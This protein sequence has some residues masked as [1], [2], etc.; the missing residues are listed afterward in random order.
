MA[1]LSDDL[2]ALRRRIDDHAEEGGHTEPHWLFNLPLSEQVF[3]RYDELVRP[4]FAGIEQVASE[5]ERPELRQG[6]ELIELTG[7]QV[8]TLGSM[9]R[10]VGFAALFTG[11]VS[12]HD[13]LVTVSALRSQ[14]VRFGTAIETRSTGTYAQPGDDQLFVDYADAVVE[15]VDAALDGRFD[16]VA[17]LETL[18]Q[19]PGLS[20]QAYRERVADV[21]RERA[22]RLSDA[23]AHRER[24]YVAAALL[25][26]AL[27]VATVVVVARSM[28]RP[29]RSLAEQVGSTAQHRLHRAVATVLETPMGLDVAVPEV[30]EITVASLDE[31]GE[32]AR[33]MNTVQRAVVGLAVEQVVLRRN[34][35]DAFVS[36]GRRNQ[37]LLSR[38]LSFITELQR[39]EADPDV[40][41][42][43]F[44]LDHLATRMRRNAESLLVLAGEE[45]PRIWAMPVGIAEVV[46]AAVGEVE[47]YQRVDLTSIEPF[48]V[49]GR[50]AADLAHL[51][52]ELI[53]NA[54]LFSPPHQRVEVRGLTRPAG[55]TIVVV[56]GGLGMDPADIAR[57]N[58]RLAGAESF[59]VAP[60]RYLGHYV[61]GH[62]AARHGIRVELQRSFG[63]GITAVV[64]LPASLDD[65]FATF[66][67][68][69]P[70]PAG[71][72]AGAGAGGRA[73]AAGNPPATT[74]GGSAPVRSE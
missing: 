6:A 38:Q 39:N 15:Q 58:R 19:P 28:T 25:T 14:F 69:A 49:R 24:L 52:A 54:L 59:T 31:V 70:A 74:T 7:R 26:G 46:R 2:A 1:S 40:L 34:M 55:Y 10:R 72:R 11:G 51:L 50:V 35:T 64:H 45:S 13:D 60:S 5:V 41:A 56:D 12:E 30:P 21:L 73:G 9:G 42:Q 37:N 20:Y 4:F 44:E 68:N 36:L 22:G 32:V 71:A 65:A 43:L 29:L 61:A 57:A 63:P 53:E 62:L 48:T 67:P 47:D 3:D 8:A 66:D 17:F 33:V 16:G 27:A 18:A 23:A